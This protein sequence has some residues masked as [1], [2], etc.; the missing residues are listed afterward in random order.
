MSDLLSVLHDVSTGLTS[1]NLD[2]LKF[3]C[4]DVIGKKKLE[5]VSSGT[6]LFQI[7]LEMQLISS[8]NTAFVRDRLAKIKR[9]D[10]AEKLEGC[11]LSSDAQIGP[12]ERDNL[13]LTF[14]AICDN[15]GR[16]WKK[17]ARKIG[18]SDA[19]LY[20]IAM[21]HPYDMREQLMEALNEWK[22]TQGKDAKAASLIHGLRE[23]NLNWTADK[24]DEALKGVS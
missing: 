9:M 16:D 15:L 14:D 2:S 20:Q 4:G 10:L 22:K 17:F 21:K 6:D 1:A 13:S 3:L 23:C 12:E 11:C 8:G 24:V 18:V 5:K 7:L 19:K